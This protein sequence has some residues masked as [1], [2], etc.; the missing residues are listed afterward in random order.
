MSQHRR[1][2]YAIVGT[3]ARAEMFVRALV[4]DHADRCELVALADPNPTR[5]RVHNDRIVALGAPRGWYCN[6]STLACRNGARR[7]SAMA[8]RAVDAGLTSSPPVTLR[9]IA[10]RSA[11]LS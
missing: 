11:L 7:S 2:R 6:S 4:T 9:L 8:R 10:H 1:V 5:M 3:G